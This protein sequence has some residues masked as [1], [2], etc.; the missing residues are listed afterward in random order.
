MAGAVFF[1]S[2]ANPR[3]FAWHCRVRR[4]HAELLFRNPAARSE[5]AAGGGPTGLTYQLACTRVDLQSQC[6]PT[7]AVPSVSG[8]ASWPREL[9]RWAISGH[10]EPTHWPTNQCRVPS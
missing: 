3:A 1:K 7:A 9:L 5:M 10:L 4:G 2:N 8:P 6:T